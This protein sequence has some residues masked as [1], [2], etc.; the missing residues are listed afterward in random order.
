MKRSHQLITLLVLVILM[1][2][3]AYQRG[4]FNHEIVDDLTFRAQQ[5]VGLVSAPS[6]DKLGHPIDVREPQTISFET[7]LL[8]TTLL[9]RPYGMASEDLFAAN[10][11]KQ[12]SGSGYELAIAA[13]QALRIPDGGLFT[14]QRS[15]VDFLSTTTEPYE[16]TGLPQDFPRGTRADDIA[17]LHVYALVMSGEAPVAVDLLAK[18]LDSKTDFTRAFCI[19]ALRAVGTPKAMETIKGHLTTVKNENNKQNYA[20]SMDI[21]IANDALA[22]AIPNFM[23]PKAFAAEVM[24]IDRFR[25]PMLRQAQ[26]NTTKSILPMMLLGYVGTDVDAA[27]IDKE[28]TFLRGLY[29]TAD[30]ALWRKYMYG[31]NALAFRSQEPFEQWLTMYQNDADATRRSFIL[32]AMS[33]QHPDRFHAEMLPLFEKEVD[34]WPQFEFL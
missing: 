23:E 7:R 6:L 4:L 5:I 22:F 2:G 12:L 26:L 9:G 19:M 24:P 21:Q 29:K 17:M 16:I 33:T 31:Y 30:Q 14:S 10:L 3:I 20:K 15:L 25:V 13:R 18:Y 28:L 34:G 11:P 32:R 1:A 8:Y 27:Q